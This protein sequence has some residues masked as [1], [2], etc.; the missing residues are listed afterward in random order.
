MI[1]EC[2]LL[3]ALSAPVDSGV[4][5]P[6]L[7]FESR[8]EQAAVARLKAATPTSGI[9]DA[10]RLVGLEGPGEPI[11]VIVAAEGT[12]IA[13]NTPS[14]IAG[15]A[16]GALGTVVLFPARAPVYPDRSLSE[17][18]VHEVTHVMVS[19]AAE[20]RHVPR[21]FNE[22]VAMAAAS[23]W[24]LNDRSWLSWA[25]LVERGGSL[26]ELDRQFEQGGGETRRAYAV[27]GAM[28]RALLQREGADAVAR[29]LRRLSRGQ[30]FESAF[31]LETGS[32]LEAFEQSFW[33]RHDFWYRWVPLLT[34]SAFLWSA[35]TALALIAIVRRRRLDAAMMARWELEDEEL[36]V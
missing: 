34:S 10:A 18:L 22:G 27:S 25:L 28:V 8:G 36:D 32:T 16:Y 23:P 26:T 17:L 6:L 9:R 33:R 12:A 5:E 35:I 4:G 2:L 13:R 7:R 30:T 15:Y 1:T 20:Q 11:E 14:W 24:G 3:I 29:V 21:W 19:R 31:L